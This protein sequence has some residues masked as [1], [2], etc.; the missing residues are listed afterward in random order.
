M[1]STPRSLS[2]E[3]LSSQLSPCLYLCPASFLP[4]C[5][6]WHLPLRNFMS[7]LV[8]L[9]VVQCPSLSRSLCK[10]SQPSRESTAIPSLVSEANLLRMHSTPLSLIKNIEQDFHVPME[11]VTCPDYCMVPHVFY[12]TPEIQQGCKIPK[13]P[14]IH[15]RNTCKAAVT[16]P[17]LDTL[18]H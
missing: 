4:R 18:Y 2:V 7:L 1:T 6:T 3:L 9:L 17:G 15:R 14:G 16:S 10:G 12:H 5:R 8:S 13:T 11:K